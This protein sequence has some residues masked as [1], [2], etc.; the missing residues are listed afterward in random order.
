M[1]MGQTVYGSSRMSTD[2]E[3]PVL[4]TLEEVADILRISL[5]KAKQMAQRG[6]LPGQLPKLGHQYRFSA[7][8]VAAYTRGEE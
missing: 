4:L 6:E 5:S 7:E 2:D 1:Q 8:R 3:K